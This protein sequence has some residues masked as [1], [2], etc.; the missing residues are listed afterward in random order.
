MQSRSLTNWINELMKTKII[1]ALLLGLFTISGMA[2]G[3]KHFN[4]LGIPID[5]TQKTFESK[6]ASK[7]FR[8]TVWKGDTYYAG[9]F[10]K[11]AVRLQ[12]SV[13]P[14]TGKTAIV[15]MI[16]QKESDGQSILSEV[17]RW[18]SKI[19]QTY[20]VKFYEKANSYNADVYSSGARGGIAISFLQSDPTKELYVVYIVFADLENLG[21]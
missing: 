8:K 18:K 20:H 3:V 9:M 12:T 10:L 5:G 7:G 14:R 21:K 17:E 15:A 13:G 19:S 2:Q 1:L 11:E 6:L 16:T 4:F